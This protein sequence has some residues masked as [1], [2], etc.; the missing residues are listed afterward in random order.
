MLYC[1]CGRQQS[2]ALHVTSTLIGYR[3]GG[4][5][6]TITR[7]HKPEDTAEK[8]RILN[9]GGKVY[10][11]SGRLAGS[12]GT[13]GTVVV[14]PYR[15]LPG[16]LSVSRTFGD[17]E[18]KLS[19]R[20]GNP[21]VVVALPEIFS[22]K[23][24]PHHDFI[25]LGCDGI[26]DK[27]SSQDVVRCVWNTMEE[28]KAE[29]VHQQCAIA[30]DSIIKNALHRRSLDNVT[31][32]IIAFANFKRIAFPKRIARKSSM[33]NKKEEAN[34]RMSLNMKEREGGYT[35]RRS[36][37][38]GHKNVLSGIPLTTRRTANVFEFKRSK[39]LKMLHE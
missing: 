20:G 28:E 8:S 15:V 31:S 13:P 25:A 39:L 5:A 29:K 38:F 18:A 4:R 32:V 37:V 7:D 10:Q 33:G 6:Q 34:K 22:F 16:R 30:A 27:L 26:F 19:T 9:A 14:G 2:R 3:N 1:Q 36:D 24:S 23:V 35:T 17:P 21:K 12:E 11:T